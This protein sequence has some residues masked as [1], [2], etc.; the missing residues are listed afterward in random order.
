M[1]VRSCLWLIPLILCFTDGAVAQL[2]IPFKK[3]D[4]DFKTYNVDSVAETLRR[5]QKQPVNDLAGELH[6]A[7]PDPSRSSAISDAPCTSFSQVDEKKLRM[8]SNAEN[9]VI[10]AYSA[11]CDST[12]LM[13]FEE[14]NKSE[15]RHLHTLRLPS[16]VQKPDISFA[17]MIQPGV[18]E[19][20]V[21]RETL[22]D[23]GGEEQENF[24]V[25]K[26]LHERLMPVLDAVEKL[27]VVMPTLVA[28]DGNTVQQ[29]QKSI[30]KTVKT[31]PKSGAVSRI[32]EKEVLTERN[33]RIT[34][35]RS[36]NWNPELERF[37]R[38]PSDDSDIAQ[39]A[40][41]ASPVKSAAKSTQPKAGSTA[42]K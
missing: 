19:V 17:E 25:L 20:L 28:D 12:Y 38:V 2:H 16:R 8:Q 32:L 29:S 39:W 18:S 11:E 24:V 22:R 42:P 41:P 14:G 27:E 30:F 3:K 37:R 7:A 33:S 10:V 31:D 15:W 34:M 36:W 35:Y 40:A 13:I 1:K 23:T 9:A 21:H 6:I 26:L 4:N 5:G